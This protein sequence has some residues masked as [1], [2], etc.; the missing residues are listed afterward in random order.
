MV[1]TTEAPRRHRQTDAATARTGTRMLTA[2]V[3]LWGTI[4]MVTGVRSRFRNTLSRFKP[5]PSVLAS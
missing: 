3:R 4:I 2:R 1:T 5:V